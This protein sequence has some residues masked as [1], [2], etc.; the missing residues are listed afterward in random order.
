[1]S[2]GSGLDAMVWDR[3]SS[4]LRQV[5][6][7]IRVAA[8]PPL[9]PAVPEADEDDI[10]ADEGRLLTRL[11]LVWERDRTLVDRKKAAR[12][13]SLPCEVCGFDFA[14]TYGRLGDEFIEAHHV[15]PLAEARASTTK[16]ADL[17]LVCSNC[18]GML[19]RPSPWVS[20]V[21]L[22]EHLRDAS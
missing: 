1:M 2:R 14:A 19:H 12:Q 11:H 16:L 21:Q 13:G 20:P 9:L 18:H 5:A 10:E 17:A 15:V 7:A 3:Y 4:Q 22:K 8:D 6:A